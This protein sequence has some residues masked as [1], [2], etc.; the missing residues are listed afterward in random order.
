ML[1][2][3]V[4]CHNASE[5]SQSIK[6]VPARNNSRDNNVLYG[7]LWH[8]Q[9]S[10]YNILRW[11]LFSSQHN[12]RVKAVFTARNTDLCWQL[13]PALFSIISLKDE[14]LIYCLKKPD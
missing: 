7:D 6:F 13:T 4:G 5:E 1:A 12:C 11:K 14:I 9:A 2:T 8:L 10:K 3:T